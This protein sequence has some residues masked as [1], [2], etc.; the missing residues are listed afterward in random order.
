MDDEVAVA[1]LQREGNLDEDVLHLRRRHRPA[2]RRRALEPLAEVAAVGVLHHEGEPLRAVGENVVEL[3]DVRVL[4][5]P[6]QHV[7]L[8]ARRRVDALRV[9]RLHHE[10]PRRPQLGAQVHLAEAA[11]ADL[12][13]PPVPAVVRLERERRRRQ[14]PAQPARHER[15]RW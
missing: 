10:Q 8:L 5:Q 3:D 14:R 4:A 11:A 7:D 12:P 2:V 9:H 13:Q 15:P 6:Q 1:V